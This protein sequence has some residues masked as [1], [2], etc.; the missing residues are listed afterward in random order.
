MNETHLIDT[1]FGDVSDCFE[2]DV[3]EEAWA[4]A[5]SYDDD[6]RSEGFAI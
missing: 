3:S 1:D 6:L 4:W 2:D 5:I